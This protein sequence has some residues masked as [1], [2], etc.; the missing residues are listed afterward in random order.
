MQTTSKPTKSSMWPSLSP[1]VSTAETN[2]RKSPLEKRRW[3]RWWRRR[4]RS[5][6]RKWNR[7]HAEKCP[8]MW[9]RTCTRECSK[10]KK[11][12]ERR[13]CKSLD[14][15]SWLRL[16]C[17][18]GWWGPNRNNSIV[19]SASPSSNSKLESCRG[20]ARS[21]SS[22]ASTRRKLKEDKNY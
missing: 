12:K 3:R 11:E 16:K 6:R 21:N 22:T 5:F 13:G 15:K 1:L 17:L 7:S 2:R 10:N 20:T 4:R 14:L 8:S 19:I 9:K 18:I